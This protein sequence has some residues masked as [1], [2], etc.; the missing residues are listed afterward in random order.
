VVHGVRK[1]QVALAER[2]ADLDRVAVEEANL[3]ARRYRLPFGNTWGDA[4]GDVDV[5]AGVGAGG[6]LV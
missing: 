6:E 5:A 3:L 2:E 4:F 1:G